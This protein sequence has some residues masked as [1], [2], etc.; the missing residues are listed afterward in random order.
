MTADAP[1]LI[2]DRPAAKW[3]VIGDLRWNRAT[4]QLVLHNQPVKIPWRAAAVFGIL[5]DARGGVVT[6]ESLERQVWG[7]IQM[8]YS[9][10]SQSIKTLRRAIDPSPSG[11]SYIETV[12]RAGY[13]LAVEA[14]DEPPAVVESA[15]PPA[16]A[17]APVPTLEPEPP[18]PPAASLPDAGH[19]RPSRWIVAAATA[20]FV[21]L[22]SASGLLYYR[23]SERRTQSGLLVDKALELIRRG[24]NESGSQG[25]LLLREALSITPDYAPATAGLAEAAARMG[26]FNFDHALEL[27]R[28]AVAADPQ[29]GDCQS[30]LGYVLAFRLWRWDEALPHLERGLQLSPAKAQHHLNLAEWLLVH[31][32]LEDAAE[33]ALEATRREPGYPRAW[34]LLAG[35]RYF[36]GQYQEAIREAE[37]AGSLDPEHPS[38]PIWAYQSYMQLGDDSN[39]AFLRAKAAATRTP[40]PA[41]IMD[42]IFPVFRAKLREGGRKTL[43]RYWIDEVG[44]G[45]ALQVHRYNRALWSMWSGDEAGALTELEAAVQSKPYHLIYAAVDPAFQPLRLNPRFRAVVRRVGLERVLD[46]SLRSSGT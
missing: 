43:L 13:R 38:G 14:V 28:Q 11:A 3:V 41:V 24:T 37:R 30:I 4:H 23:K 22:A 44:A 15:A 5:V 9:V 27:A 29:C 35:I 39:A 8:D 36:Q 2:P 16:D 20:V 26:E 19:R 33:R 32:R 10:L 31:G 42:S 17:S 7:D 1:N 6:R 12:A 45:K 25:V 46:A 18:V 34:A 21:L 40:N